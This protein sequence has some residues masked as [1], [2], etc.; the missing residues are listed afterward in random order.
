VAT[1]SS[2]LS[3]AP[4]EETEAS[5]AAKPKA[6]APDA[7]VH[8]RHDIWQACI[9]GAGAIMTAG[10]GARFFGMIANGGELNGVR[11]VPEKTLR[12]C[13]TP[14]A[15]SHLNDK[16]LYGG[17]RIAPPIGI[18]GFW[19]S[20]PLFGGGPSVL[21]HTGSGGS[22]GWADLDSGLAVSICHNRLF[23]YPASRPLDGHPYYE[24]YKG[25]T[26]I[27]SLDA[28]RSSRSQPSITPC[29]N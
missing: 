20:L 24:I 29:R 2:E 19:L 1:L 7:P 3:A 27:S 11:I 16:V 14:R 21:C 12:M 25:V 10:A 8:N 6:V 15:T 23:E 4:I 18:G 22:I 5:R 26:T 13:T 28:C 17:D 9:P